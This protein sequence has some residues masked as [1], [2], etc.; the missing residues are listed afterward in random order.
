MGAPWPSNAAA[1]LLS[2]FPSHCKR[3]ALVQFVQ[4]HRDTAKAVRI[5]M[6]EV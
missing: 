5:H 3:H 1:S 2:Q 4:Y 6:I